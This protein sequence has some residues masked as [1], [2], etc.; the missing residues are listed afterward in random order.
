MFPKLVSISSGNPCEQQLPPPHCPTCR[1]F[2]RTPDRELVF[3]SSKMKAVIS[4][5]QT[6]VESDRPY[7]KLI[8]L[9]SCLGTLLWLHR[10]L[11]ALNILNVYVVDA[12]DLTPVVLHP[13]LHSQF[14]HVL[15][16]P[17]QAVQFQISLPPG[18][19]VIVAEAI[20]ADV[21]FYLMHLLTSFRIPNSVNYVSMVS[22]GTVEEV[23]ANVP[24]QPDAFDSFDGQVFVG[25]VFHNVDRLLAILQTADQL[26]RD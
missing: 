7:S 20:V 10:A 4:R 25:P 23:I 3:P 15:L 16:M 22:R 2:V 6:F 19:M 13:F 24:M 17:I 1:G 21:S 11:H 8:I 5:A 14:L 9:S 12:E 18:S 26:D